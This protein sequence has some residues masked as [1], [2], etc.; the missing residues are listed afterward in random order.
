MSF[1]FSFAWSWCGSDE[2]SVGTR[3]TPSLSS[4]STS[5]PS[6]L[7]HPCAI[8]APSSL[9]RSSSYT[10]RPVSQCTL[11]PL[12]F[13]L[14]AV[15]ASSLRTR[16]LSYALAPPIAHSTD[17]ASSFHCW[18]SGKRETKRKEQDTSA[19]LRT[20]SC[21]F[22][23]PLPP[24]RSLLLRRRNQRLENPRRDAP[25]HDVIREHALDLLYISTASRT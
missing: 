15:F 8:T 19:H 12:A 7:P 11:A 18:T 3:S 2:G 5:S 17:P 13:R 9:P 23:L 22:L 4:S 14:P 16:D 1:L 10:F 24:L 6:F 21:R 20:L 25:N